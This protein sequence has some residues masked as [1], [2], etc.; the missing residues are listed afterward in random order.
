[1]KPLG[2]VFF[3]L[4]KIKIG[5]KAFNS[6]ALYNGPENLKKI[7]KFYYI[8]LLKNFFGP[9]GPKWLKFQARQA[10]PNFQ[11]HQAWVWGLI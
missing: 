6:R 7:I 5:L 4:L 9:F 3:G 8:S 11:A 2:L 1:L 10:L